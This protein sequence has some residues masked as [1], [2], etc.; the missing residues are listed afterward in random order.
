MNRPGR[1]LHSFWRQ[2][3]FSLTMI[4]SV[5]FILLTVGAMAFYSGGTLIDPTTSGYSFLRNYFSDLGLTWSHARQP[6]TVSAVL[7]I[8]ALTMAG[9]GLILFFLAFPRFFICS[10]SGKVLSIIG[11]AFGVIAGLCFIGVA[12]TPANLYLGTHLT[13]MM[14]AFRTFTVAVICYTIAIFREPD[15]P[16]RYGFVFVAFGVLLV[17]YVLL[18]VAG[19]AYDSPEGIVIQAVGQKIIVYASVTSVL[20]QAYGARRVAA[21]STAAGK[22]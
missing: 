1:M 3:V 8:T 11:S 5:L 4:G 15:Y 12:L 17:L 9:G 13:I 14:W 19:P 21:E 10:R 22:R 7:F 16:N 6:N 20:I 18:L 2:G